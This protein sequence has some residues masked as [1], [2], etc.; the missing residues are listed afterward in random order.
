MG[1][2]DTCQ[3]Q[4]QPYATE[5]RRMVIQCYGSEE[6]LI[7]EVIAKRPLREHEASPASIIINAV[8][9]RSAAR[10]H[11][12]HRGD[13]ASRYGTVGELAGLISLHRQM[14]IRAL[15]SNLPAREEFCRCSPV[16]EPT[17]E[18][19]LS[20]GPSAPSWHHSLEP[21]PN[22]AGTA[23]LE[24]LI[25]RAHLADRRRNDVVRTERPR[26]LPRARRRS[27]A[28]YQPAF[29]FVLRTL[30]RRD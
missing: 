9:T 3:K 28:R 21:T 24:R 20:C 8:G 10:R 15:S 23:L 6:L 14:G 11:G 1:I 2:L 7:G 26:G 19:L 12:V 16:Q 5:F 30:P 27:R 29:R 13:I 18:S 4:G 17:S 22:R 25:T